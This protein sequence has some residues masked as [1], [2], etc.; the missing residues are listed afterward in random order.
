MSE[1]VLA[2]T[3]LPGDFDATKLA[4]ELVGSGFAACVNILPAVKSVYTWDGLPQTDQEQQL[5]IKTTTDQ[6]DALWDALRARHPY[7]VP[8]FI[9]VPVI[10]GSQDYLRW[11]ER[12]L[13]SQPHLD[14]RFSDLGRERLRQL[15]ALLTEIEWPQSQ[16]ETLALSGLCHRA[17]GGPPKSPGLQRE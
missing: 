11:V 4:H 8:E 12:S 16:A 9:V 3:T 5:F 6:I 15:D 2:L 1:I 7:D 17:G 14:V 10:D 13:V